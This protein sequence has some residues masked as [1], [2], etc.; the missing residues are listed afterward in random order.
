ML[1]AVVV[2]LGACGAALAGPPRPATDDEVKAMIAEAGDAESF[3]GADIVYVLDE[4]DVYVRPT[5]VATTESRQVVKLLTEKGVK[6]ESVQRFEFDPATNR[7]HVRAARIHRA[8][9]TI[10]DVDV[11]VVTQPARQWSIYWGNQQHVLALPGLQV[12]DSVELRLSRTGYN[13]AY[14]HDGGMSAADYRAAALA[15]ADVDGLTPP[16]PGEW[17]EVTLFQSGDPILHKRYS[18][19]MPKDMPV[20]Y[21]VY[22]GPLRNSLWFDGDYHIYTWTADDIPAVKREPHMVALDDAVPKVVMATVGT[23]EEKS[24]WFYEANEGQFAA[25][26]AIRAKV[27]ELIE[28]LDTDEDK[29]AA[30]QHWVADNVRYYGTSRGPCEGFTI[31]RSVETF[32]DRGGV[33][34]DK[35]GMLVTMLRVAGFDAYAAL[36]MAGSRVEAIP[37]DQFNHT[38]TILRKKDGTFMILDPTWV[39][40]SR[41]FWSSRE[42]EQHLVYGTPE[43]QPLTQSPYFEPEY[44]RLETQAESIILDNGELESR[45]V[46]NMHG[47]PCTYL[48][49]SVERYPEDRQRAAF[50][51]ALNIAPNA[52]LVSLDHTDPYD[53]TEDSKV[54]MTVAADRYAL[55]D[56]GTHMFR[57]PLMSHPLADFF[58]SDVVEP[59]DKP[60]R[61]YGLRMRATRLVRYDETIKLPPGWKVEHVPDAV[62]MDGPAAS[63]SFEATPGNGELHYRF[64]LALKKHIIGPE[65]YPALRKA[66]KAMHAI[67]DDW[68]LC[69]SGGGDEPSAKTASVI[70]EGKVRHE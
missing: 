36:T 5:G 70:E 8:D 37:A 67:S 25:D 56:A 39:P 40:L 44:N 10:E 28:G 11:S 7:L 66:L 43:G 49:R 62:K 47:Y 64:E 6:A 14:L 35:A 60:E 21:E 42:A 55:G 26:D 61:T 22:N 57:L 53:Y 45:I 20:Q 63:I 19:H 27:R 48:R 32:Q 29:I 54:D 12:G 41:E 50:E 59:L 58:L 51:R 2:G 46:M 65:E 9:G 17:F 15:S 30:L 38:V 52:R 33:C 23:W 69:S 16:M 3:K 18:V 24:R 68:V 34:K 1:L 31:H 4:A 13:I